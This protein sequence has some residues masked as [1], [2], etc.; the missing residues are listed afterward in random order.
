[1]IVR[2]AVRPCSLGSILVAATEAGVC[3]LFL[4][5]DPATLR[6]N[7][8]TRFPHAEHVDGDREF[9]VWVAEA[10]GFVDEPGREFRA[11]LDLRG[12]EF[13]RQVWE[14]LRAVPAGRTASYTAIAERIGRPT[15][16][17]A[18]AQACGANPVAIAVPCHRILRSDDSLSGYRWGVERKAELL[19]REGTTAAG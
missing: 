4:G 14:A 13:Q 18:V 1:M 6:K 11:P 19:R 15:A 2:H 7:L 8:R 9:E 5:D 16:A 17:R 3:A 10:V 12:T